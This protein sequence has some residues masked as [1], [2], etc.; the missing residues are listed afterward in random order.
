[1]LGIDQAPGT[2]AYSDILIAPRVTVHEDCPSAQ[3]AHDTIRGRVSVAWTN[4]TTSFAL[5]ATTPTNTRATVR[6]PFAA[7]AAGTLAATEGGVTFYKAGA[8]VPG[9]AGITAAAVD[10]ASGTLAVTVG[11]GTYAFVATW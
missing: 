9:V 2:Y 10:A 6:I 11:S 5:A 1:V 8:F 7:G 4:A 3:G